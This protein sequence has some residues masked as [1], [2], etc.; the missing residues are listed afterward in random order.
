M[1]GE[2]RIHGVIVRVESDREDLRITVVDARG[3]EPR[4]F[5]TW[6]ELTTYL[7]ALARRGNRTLR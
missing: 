6:G 3:G 4:T 1:R 2:R 5:T 7:Q